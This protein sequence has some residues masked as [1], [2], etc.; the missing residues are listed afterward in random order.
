MRALMKALMQ[1]LMR[2]LVRVLV[3]ALM[4]AL[5]PSPSGEI[6]QAPKKNNLKFKPPT[7]PHCRRPA[8]LPVPLPQC[9]A[10]SA[11]LAPPKDV[12]PS[13]CSLF[14]LEYEPR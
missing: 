6:S 2:A 12:F 8:G 13:P 3:Q 4:L 1:A 14:L 11:V 9:T 7:Q 10:V 5:M